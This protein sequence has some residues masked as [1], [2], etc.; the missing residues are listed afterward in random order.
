MDAAPQIASKSTADQKVTPVEV[1]FPDRNS[2]ADRDGRFGD[3]PFAGAGDSADEANAAFRIEL[4]D[5]AQR[6]TDLSPIEPAD[7]KTA[8]PEQPATPEDAPQAAAAVGEP[9]DAEDAG[10]AATEDGADTNQVTS[11]AQERTGNDTR[12]ET[13]AGRTLGQVIDAFA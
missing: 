12:N 7:P 10:V 13:E 9:E 6:L 3:S 1:V 4:S 2:V 5:A 8:E 11:F